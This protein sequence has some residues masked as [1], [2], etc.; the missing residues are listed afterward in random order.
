MKTIQTTKLFDN[1]FE[2]LRDNQAKAKIRARIQRAK[3][4]NLG[5][6]KP[7]GSG[8]SEMRIHYGA[9][10]RVYFMQ[11][12]SEIIIL[13]AGGDKSTQTKDIECALQIADEIK[14]G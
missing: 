5:D 2:N 3:L 9:G 14:R 6:C 8:I 10:Y 4:G 11:Q 7:V 13:L 1:W 12:G